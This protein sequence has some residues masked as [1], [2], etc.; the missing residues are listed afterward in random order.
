MNTRQVG[1]DKEKLAEEYQ[2]GMALIFRLTPSHYHR[3]SYGISG[4]VTEE[5][6]IP[7]ILHCVR[8]I[9]TGRIPVFV[10]NARQYQVIETNAFGKVVQME[11]GALMVGKIRNHKRLQN[12]FV[13]PNDEKG[14]FQFGGST[15][16]MLFKK[17]QLKL[18]RSLLT[19]KIP[20]GELM[21]RKGMEIG[22][23]FQ[24]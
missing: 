19:Q 21:V 3:Y 23:H 24:K 2:D 4:Q 15:I 16:I 5:K 17:D 10:Q 9:V 13:T 22:R 6:K 1:T 7:G 14:Y 20:T 8:P 12:E 18:K 11:V